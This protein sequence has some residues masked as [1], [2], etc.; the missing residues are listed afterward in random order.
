M[1]HPLIRG[2]LSVLPEPG[3]ELE[4]EFK[5]TRLETFAMNMNF[6]YRQPKAFKNAS[7]HRDPA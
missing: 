2:L 3:A 7:V 5:K 1:E 6:I 4:E